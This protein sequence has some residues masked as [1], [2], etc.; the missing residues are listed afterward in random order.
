M[1]AAD[2]VYKTPFFSG[3]PEKER[4]QRVRA[5]P[6]EAQ[7]R[8]IRVLMVTGINHLQNN[9]TEEAIREFVHILLLEPD[10]REAKSKLLLAYM[11]DCELNSRNCDEALYLYGL[12]SPGEKETLPIDLAE[13]LELLELLNNDIP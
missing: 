11:V 7:Q 6:V 12:L 9:E 4:I 2:I 5:Q 3:E 1:Y 10:H 13:K 8:A